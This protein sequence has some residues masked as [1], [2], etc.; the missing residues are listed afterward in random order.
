[1]L[2][3]V[4][5]S[6]TLQLLETRLIA[7]AREVRGRAVV[8]LVDASHPGKAEGLFRLY[9]VLSSPTVLVLRRGAEL[10]RL[11]GLRTLE[12]YSLAL[13]SALLAPPDAELIRLADSN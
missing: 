3:F 9:Q 10:G 11:T 2:G 7:I 12:Q 1:M 4:R 6:N 8:A 5:G 13:D